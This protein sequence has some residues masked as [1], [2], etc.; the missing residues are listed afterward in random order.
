MN[1]FSVI[2]ESFFKQI[3]KWILDFLLNRHPACL[4][5]YS[6][7]MFSRLSLSVGTFAAAVQFNFLRTKRMNIQRG[8]A[9]CTH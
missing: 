3:F 4:R 9:L 2:F 1:F 7:W 6:A 5:F 8:V